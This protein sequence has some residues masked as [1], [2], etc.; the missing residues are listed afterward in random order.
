[1]K[2]QNDLMDVSCVHT[3]QTIKDYMQLSMALY[4]MLYRSDILKYHI[5]TGNACA[6]YS[7]DVVHMHK[8]KHIYSLYPKMFVIALMSIV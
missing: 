7:A 6:K 2:I 1:M 8:L 3:L 4:M 5:P